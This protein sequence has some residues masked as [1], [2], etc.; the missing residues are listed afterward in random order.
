MSVKNMVRLTIILIMAL[1]M[2]GCVAETMTQI[3][4][5]ISLGEGAT[6]GDIRIEVLMEA[7]QSLEQRDVGKPTISTSLA[8]F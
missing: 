8:P 3:P 4:L 6:C 1:T 2:A 7:Q 5:T